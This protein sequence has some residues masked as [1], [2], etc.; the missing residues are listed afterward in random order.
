MSEELIPSGYPEFLKEVKERIRTAQVRAMVVVNTEAILLYWNIGREILLK[1][2]ELSWGAKVV[3]RL[4][5]DLRREFPE[6][7]GFSWT[8]LLYMRLWQQL[9]QMSYLSKRCS[10][11]LP[12]ITTSRF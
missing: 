11:K 1:Q 5:K 7:K 4:S 3:E 8:N 2:Q 12:G 6:M 10:D 9:I